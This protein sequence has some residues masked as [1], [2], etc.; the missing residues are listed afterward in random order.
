MSF[1]AQSRAPKS[2]ANFLWCSELRGFGVCIWPTCRQ[3]FYADKGPDITISRKMRSPYQPPATNRTL[4]Y[5][6]AVGAP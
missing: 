1:S 3:V 5:N 4:F 2:A 6:Y